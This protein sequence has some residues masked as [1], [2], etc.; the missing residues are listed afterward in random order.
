MNIYFM[1]N[2]NIRLILKFQNIT[3]IITHIRRMNCLYKVNVK[4]F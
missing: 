4:I 3:G 2:I 1:L